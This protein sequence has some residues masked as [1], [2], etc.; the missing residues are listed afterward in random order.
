MKWRITGPARR[1]LAGIWSY[2]QSNWD[3]RQA[4]RY[5]D[6]LAAR[7]VWLT[8]NPNMW[9]ARS[10]IRDGLFSYSEGRHLI[11]FKETSGMLT[12][13]RVLHDR[14]DIRRHV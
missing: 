6:L 10:D 12:V 9:T 5:L 7:I 4:D 8:G 1:D 13:I 11:I 14:M 3:V 2:T